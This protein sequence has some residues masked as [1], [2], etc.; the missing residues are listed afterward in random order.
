MLAY[1]W[2]GGKE[3]EN[4]DD[5]INTLEQCYSSLDVPFNPNDIDRAHCI[6]L[7]YTDNHSRKKAKSI[8]V[9]FR[10][11]KARQFFYKSRPRYHTDGSKKPGF[12]VSVDLTKRRYLLLSKAKVKA[13]VIQI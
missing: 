3:K 12:S 5:V 6:G 4:E 9:K 8:I 1:S 2:S 13:K 10:S 11:W 7:S